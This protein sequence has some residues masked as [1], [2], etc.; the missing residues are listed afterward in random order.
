ML[1]F[2]A[3]LSTTESVLNEKYFLDR[4]VYLSYTF[5]IEAGVLMLATNKDFLNIR[6]I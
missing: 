2:S 1:S 5:F 6:R 3:F 4:S